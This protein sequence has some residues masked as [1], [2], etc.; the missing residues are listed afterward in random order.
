MP[1]TSDPAEMNAAYADTVPT[2]V[3]ALHDGRI[4]I[5][6]QVLGLAEAG[7]LATLEKRLAIRFPWSALPA[8]LWLR[9]LHAV[10]PGGADL[11][12]PWPDLVIG[13][14]RTTAAPAAAIRRA[15]GGR[16]FV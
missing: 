14:G 13:C 12:P 4:G 8:S 2:V 11:A 5:A 16:S 3:W 6:N 15:S 9:P 1:P 7:G 10:G